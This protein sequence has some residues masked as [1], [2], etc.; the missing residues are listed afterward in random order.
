MPGMASSSAMMSWAASSRPT[1]RKSDLPYKAKKEDTGLCPLF[2]LI[3][4]SGDG[5]PDGL[6]YISQ[7]LEEGAVIAALIYL[8]CR[9]VRLGDGIGAQDHLYTLR[10]R[11]AGGGEGRLPG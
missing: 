8:L 10:L 3:K 2:Y 6:E 7:A 9:C 1:I 11:V 4:Q 5:I